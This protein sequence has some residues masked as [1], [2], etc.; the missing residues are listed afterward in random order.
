MFG[1]SGG[2]QG[3]NETYDL[4]YAT[5]A[6]G[7]RG[8]DAFGVGGPIGDATGDG[9]SDYLTG[10]GSW[11]G[12]DQ[13]IVL[14]L[15]GGPYIPND[16]TTLSVQ[17]VATDEHR[18]ALHIWPNPVRDELHVAWR[19]DLKRPPGLL[20]IYDMNGRLI[21]EGPVNTGRGE[22]IWKCGSVASGSYLLV[23]CD[24]HGTVLAQTTLVKQ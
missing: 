24:R 18:A 9:Y 13:G 4:W 22:A 10:N 20:R 11:G 6:D 3:P 14:L 21:V 2:K 5:S 19:G 23:V 15:A 1:L 17:S 16:D 7:M 8:G 12:L